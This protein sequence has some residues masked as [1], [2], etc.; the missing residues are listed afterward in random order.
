MFRS[1]IATVSVL[2]LL[3]AGTPQALASAGPTGREPLRAADTVL[4]GTA[5]DDPS[6]LGPR[7]P[8]E[9]R[10]RLV[11]VDRKAL[12][13]LCEPPVAGRPDAVTLNLFPDVTVVA[14]AQTVAH[15]DSADGVRVLG[16]VPDEPDSQVTL[17]AIGLCGADTA[18]LSLAGSVRFTGKEFAIQPRSGDRAVI[19][20]IDSMAAGLLERPDHPATRPLPPGARPQ[21]RL[22]ETPSRG[23]AD[24]TV[25]DVLVLYTPGAVREAGGV[26]EI[27][28]WISDAAQRANGNLA[29]SGVHVAFRIVDMEE[30]T[31]YRG[32]ETVEPAFQH[33]ADT[34]DGQL[35]EAVRLRERY[36]A[37]VV[38]TVVAAYD[39]S[40]GVAGMASYPEN[41]KNPDTS[42]QIWSVVAA[43]Q[44]WAFVLAHEWGHLLGLNHDWRTSPETDPYYPDNHG[45]IAPDDKFVTI[46]GYPTA[47]TRACPYAPYFAN[48]GLSYK[49]EKL[50]VRLGAPFSAD[51]ARVM[52]ITGREVAAYRSAKAR[53]PEK[54]LTIAAV[55]GGTAKPEVLGPYTGGETVAVDARPAPGYSL[56]GWTLDGVV[57][58]A[59]NPIGIPMDRDHTLAP[60]FE[61]GA[62]PS[63]RLTPVSTPA[64]SGDITLSPRQNRYPEG[65]QVT[66]AAMPR[67]GFA[68]QG[69]TLDGRAAGDEPALILTMTGDHTVAARFAPARRVS[70]S[71]SPRSGGTAAL[72][73]TRPV[74]DGAAVVARAKPATGYLFSHWVRNG[75]P[76]GTQPVTSITVAGNETLVAVFTPA[77]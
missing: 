53:P 31:G 75:K 62:R 39:P 58:P 33:L 14:E 70:V 37:D 15:T 48:P 9:L 11:T 35:D 57:M 40:T 4:F 3:A 66:A 52:N 46:M 67:S 72:T 7:H 42:D 43:N 64:A 55:T 50:G 54:R 13:P 25:I 76:A 21:F 10:Q 60:R 38:T 28:A 6:A 45:F 51:N 30:A 69:W 20:E 59:R 68:F 65:R 36:G 56:T 8:W 49:G 73:G 77:A 24:N 22:R 12:H 71:S 26:N 2:L 47:C 61:P 32:G 44:L 17:T 29:D 41:P 34:G 27:A 19:S 63:H 5:V 1:R 74:A 18:G 23:A 16:V